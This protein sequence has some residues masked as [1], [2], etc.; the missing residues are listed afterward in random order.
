MTLL[1]DATVTEIARELLRREQG[2]TSETQRVDVPSVP[3]ERGVHKG[4]DKRAA[5]ERG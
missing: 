1:K 3:V 2:E 5:K 4:R